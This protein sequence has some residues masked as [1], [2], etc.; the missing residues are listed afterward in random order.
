MKNSMQRHHGNTPNQSVYN[1]DIESEEAPLG[2]GA[3]D[4]SASLLK[5]SDINHTM[6]LERQTAM[7]NRMLTSLKGGIMKE[8]EEQLKNE[9]NSSEGNDEEGCGRVEKI[10]H[11]KVT[12]EKSSEKWSKHDNQETGKREDET[13]N[14]KMY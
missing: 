4:D 10:E 14:D 2:K 5:L 12:M 3:R 11:K 13:R 6:R 9:E 1:R 7:M 8:H